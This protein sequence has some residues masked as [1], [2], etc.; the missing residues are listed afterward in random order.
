MKRIES[1]NS[2]VF[3][4]NTGWT[5]GPHGIGSRF[6][7]PTTR[8]IIN[9]IQNGELNDVETAHIDGLNLEVPVE[10]DGV[11]PKVLI[12][13]N[14]WSD[15]NQYDQYLQNLIK[16]FKDN[17]TKFSVSEEIITAGPT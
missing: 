15:Q 1:F 5:G 7:I 10:I 6:D 8:R 4:V 2:R 14:T 3:L 12:P 16:Q 17:F 9:A 11:D 13:K